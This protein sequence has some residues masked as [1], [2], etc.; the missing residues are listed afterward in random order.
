MPTVYT[1]SHF[2]HLNPFMPAGEGQVI[3]PCTKESRQAAPDD[4]YSND[5]LWR[6]S[7]VHLSCLL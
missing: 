2:A 6:L 4:A 5:R 7:T 3:A 1:T